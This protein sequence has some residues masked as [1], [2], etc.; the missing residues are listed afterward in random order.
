MVFCI[1]IIFL[2]VIISCLVRNLRPINKS[3]VSVVSIPVIRLKVKLT[4]NFAVPHN[5]QALRTPEAGT[6]T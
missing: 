4:H 6:L 3:Y 2:V 5:S 1:T